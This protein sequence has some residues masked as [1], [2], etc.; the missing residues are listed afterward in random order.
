MALILPGDVSGNRRVPPFTLDAWNQFVDD[1]PLT[2]ELL[3]ERDWADLDPAQRDHYDDQRIDVHSEFIVVDTAT[4]QETMFQG[5][6]LRRVNK[7]ESS[8]R[9]GLI[10]SGDQATGK[11]TTIKQLGRTHELNVR[12]NYPGSDRIPVVYITAPPKGSPKKLAAQFVKFL[13]MPPFKSRANEIDIAD[14]VCAVLVDAMT[15]FVIVDEI[16][17]V[18]LATSQDEDLSDH[19]KYFTEQL[20]CTFIYAGINVEKSGLFTGIR[21]KQIRARCVMI[22]TGKFLYNT[23]WR[24]MIGTMDAALRLHRHEP[25][26]LVKHAKI[27]SPAVR[28]RD[29]QCLPPGPRRSHPRHHERH[30]EDHP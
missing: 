20:P 17:N 10:V 22:K 29:Q 1:D 24:S 15:E 27:P 9:R 5:M 7:R 3:S 30:R 12:A 21:G 23:E 11:S 19:L 26:S 13:G 2:I 8:A 18:N 16:H 4:V 14:A 28:R 25:G 6:L